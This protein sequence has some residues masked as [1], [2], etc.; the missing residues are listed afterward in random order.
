[1]G[2]SGAERLTRRPESGPA[3]REETSFV[4]DLR[5]QVADRRSRDIPA[6]ARFLNEDEGLLGASRFGRTAKS[7]MDMIGAGFLLV[8]LAPLLLVIAFLVKVTSRGPVLFSQ[9]RVGLDG[10]TFTM[11]KFRTMVEDA[12]SQRPGLVDLNEQDGPVFKIRND[13]RITFLGRYLRRFSLDELP[14][15]LNVLSRSMSLVGPRPA[16]PSEVS[17]YNDWERQ[18]LRVKPG[19]TCTW[20]VNGRSNVG[21]ETWVR[22]DV[23]YIGDWSL[24]A[25][26]KLLARTLP[27][28]VRRDGAH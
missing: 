9:E 5:E 17:T 3:R 14:Q 27:A 23:D 4:I 22:M 10:E 15:L 21:F 12:E 16:L 2:A 24:L 19:L 8:A 20:Q 6:G 11:F 28:V 26:V 7:S 25:D 1:M 18:R 13:P